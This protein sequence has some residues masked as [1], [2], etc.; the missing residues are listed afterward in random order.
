MN[1]KRKIR[2]AKGSGTTVQDVNKLLKMHQEMATAMKKISK[3][4]GLGKLGALFGG[5]G[6]GGL[7]GAGRLLRPWRRPAGFPVAAQSTSRPA[8]EKLSRNRRN[9]KGRIKMA[10]AIGLAGAARRSGLITRSWW[11]TPARARRQVHRADRQL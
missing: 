2:V 9:Q 11:R 5:G 4:G 7:G 10:V 3:M 8:S 1:A 6:M